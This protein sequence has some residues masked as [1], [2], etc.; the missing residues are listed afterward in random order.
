MA[1]ALEDA[2][3]DAPRAHGIAVLVGHDPGELMQM[4]EV[5]ADPS[6]EKLRERHRAESGMCAAAGQVFELEAKGLQSG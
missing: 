1:G 4:R 2:E 5:V 6:G 3:V